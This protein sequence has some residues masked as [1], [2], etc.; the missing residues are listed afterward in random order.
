MEIP[1][2]LIELGQNIALLLS[3]VFIYSLIRPHLKRFSE[4]IQI[5]ATGMLFAII[6]MIGMLTPIQ[7]SEGIIIDSR[8]VI[9]ALAGLFG[10]LGPGAL[11]ASVVSLYRLYLGGIG[12][13]PGIGAIVTGALIG[14]WLHRRWAKQAYHIHGWQFLL[15][16]IALA[17]QGLLWTFL[18]PLEIALNAIQIFAI[19]VLAFYPLG[20]FFLG[21]IFSHQI[22][23]YE[24]EEALRESEE[25]LRI[26]LNSIGDAVIATDAK[27]TITRMNPV[28]ENLTNWS[29]KEAYGQPLTKVFHI[30]HEE[31]RLPVQ[32]PVDQ[33]LATKQNVGLMNHT[34][35]VAKDGSEHQIADSGAPIQDD[36][37]KIIGVV[38][39]FRDVTEQMRTEQ[40]LLKA[41]KLE[42]VGVLA[43]GIAHDFNNLLAGFFGNIDLAK[44]HIPP[45]HKAYKYLI[46]AENAIE[47]ATNLTKQLLTFAK[48]GDPIKETLTIGDVITETAKFSLR[49]SNVRLYTNI[50][51]NL[52]PVEADKGQLSQVISNLV[53]NAQQAMPTGGSITINADNEETLYGRFIK[54]TV[55]DEGIGIAP[56]H[57]EKIFDP[58]F[59]NKEEG[60]GLGL[61]SSHSIIKKH[62]GR[63]SV[64]SKLNEG[65]IFTIILPAK[66]DTVELPFIKKNTLTDTKSP[67]I[68]PA[69]I[70]VMDDKEIVRD[71]IGEM[72]VE[73]G[74]QVEFAEDGQEAISKYTL[75]LESNAPFDLV[76]TD[77][78]IPGG[79]SGQDAAKEILKLDPD[80]TLIVSSGYA[81]DPVMA[82]YEAY[83]FKAIVTKPYQSKALEEAIQKALETK[84][85]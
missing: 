32:N 18:L 26:T 83:G 42:S 55:Q 80:A 69:Y 85:I 23:R 31:T 27:G 52:W 8:V 9:V 25:N 11:A 29:L 81:N 14:V 1:A 21:M 3:L 19:P 75:A 16:G 54:I 79:M 7:I 40:E 84:T 66:I 17:I 38:L 68:L 28:A 24:S 77:L 57:L 46:N 74:H 4:H 61:A 48:G 13:L 50:N 6:A 41:K 51:A 43:G 67:E 30:I 12:I 2:I 63:I 49:G 37:D 36:N 5:L 72:L 20:T 60:S 71:T 59:S 78:T 47:R 56:E 82:N 73:Q 22:R 33:I 44:I 45:D 10:G 58:Y 34:I 15:L 70:L 62:N 65:T 53:I 39:V 64:K 35:L 76:I